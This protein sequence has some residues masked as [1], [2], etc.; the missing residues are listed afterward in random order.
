MKLAWKNRKHISVRIRCVVSFFVFCQANSFWFSFLLIVNKYRL[1]FWVTKT[2]QGV[3]NHFGDSF[4]TLCELTVLFTKL[5]AGGWNH[6]VGSFQ[7]PATFMAY[8]SF[9][10]CTR[11]NH[12]TAGNCEAGGFVYST[13]TA[14][15]TKLPASWLPA[16]PYFAW[17]N[18]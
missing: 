16:V 8:G 12:A 1:V 10:N 18:S 13:V 6:P 3:N 4:C 17:D 11:Q 9:R 14:L 15:F 5:P 2:H 7:P